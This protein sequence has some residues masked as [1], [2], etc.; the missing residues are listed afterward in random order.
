MGTYENFLKGTRDQSG[1]WG[2]IRHFFSGNIQKTFLGIMGDFGYFSREH[3][4]TDSLR[5]PQNAS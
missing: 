2:A 5:G 3:G 4:N 1:F